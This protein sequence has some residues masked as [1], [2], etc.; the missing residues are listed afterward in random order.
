VPCGTSNRRF[1]MT[2]AVPAS[3]NRCNSDSLLQPRSTDTTEY[4]PPPS[5]PS[6]CSLSPDFLLNSSQ[7]MHS[8]TSPPGVT[9][10][11]RLAPPRPLARTS[12]P[13]ADSDTTRV[14]RPL[15][16]LPLAMAHIGHIND[17]HLPQAP[18]ASP[19]HMPQQR[20]AVSP[21]LRASPTLEMRLQ[22]L[23]A[24][25][26]T[27]NAVACSSSSSS[28]SS[29]LAVLA[30]GQE[31]RGEEH[32]GGEEAGG[33]GSHC[34]AMTRAAADA[35][36]I[37]SSPSPPRALRAAASLATGEACCEHGGEGRA[38]GGG[39][40]DGGG[41]DDGAWS[42]RGGG[43]GG[44]SGAGEAWEVVGKWWAEESAE[45][46]CGGGG[47]GGLK[48]KARGVTVPVVRIHI[49]AALLVDDAQYL[50]PLLRNRHSDGAPLV[51]SRVYWCE[52]L[53]ASWRVYACL[54]A[55]RSCVARDRASE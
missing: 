41:A 3:S 49:D 8:S 9:S 6:R 45:S 37:A 40:G 13:P 46:G 31:E 16:R 25:I 23:S 33:G 27:S 4:Q 48:G 43:G 44:A 2:E 29:H 15:P 54:H 14:R 22:Q 26:A 51:R 30:C 42:T 21:A 18:P 12:P 55:C 53:H 35:D 5:P 32:G 38:R 11:A 39:A 28:R 19:P 10:A 17:P 36:S 34:D 50:E 1:A 20:R 24:S 52:C 47:E 7:S